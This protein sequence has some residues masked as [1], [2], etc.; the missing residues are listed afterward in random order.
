MDIPKSAKMMAGSNLSNNKAQA[1]AELAIF[2]SILLFCVGALI[3]AGLQAN[4]QQSIQ[5]DVFR[6]AQ[7]IAYK[8]S[9]PGSTASV[10][11]IK[12]KPF[13]TPQ[14]QWG[15]AERSPAIAAAGVTWDNNITAQYVLSFA[16][17]AKAEDLPVSYFGVSNVSA[18]NLATIKA[19][20]PAAG[21]TAAVPAGAGDDLFG[22]YGARFDKIACTGH[23]TVYMDDPEHADP[24]NIQH[25][26]YFPLNVP[27]S[28]IV[29]MLLSGEFGAGTG[30][31]DI[32]DTTELLMSPYYRYSTGCDVNN[33]P[34]GMKRKIS[35]ADV[36]N[37]QQ[38]EEII[39]ANKNKMF[40]YVDRSD[41]N[42]PTRPGRTVNGTIQIDSRYT[43][44]SPYPYGEAG[45][46]LNDRQG[47]IPDSRKTSRLNP[48]T[49]IRRTEDG[50][51]NIVSSTN[52]NANQTIYHQIRLNDGGQPVEVP[53]QF[54][55]N[56]NGAYQW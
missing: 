47:L 43:S 23:I 42:N 6:R 55:V 1:L 31:P 29:V 34:G 37:D 26:E 49:Q 22:Y 25:T 27:C 2:G 39:A 8:K 4:Y 24:N 56:K 30:D 50:D 11:L 7:Q 12:D 33:C 53:S 13:P 36:D 10:V 5:M 16:E 41:K 20:T 3:Q 52:I 35:V 17:V 14:D 51:G 15:F 44:V 19:G 46:A 38:Q 45:V 54:G 48:G 9:G 21:T 28:Q 32:D 18:A 40:Y